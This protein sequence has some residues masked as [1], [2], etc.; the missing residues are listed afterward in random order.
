[1]N[2]VSNTIQLGGHVFDLVKNEVRVAPDGPSMSCLAAVEQMRVFHGHHT[3]IECV[4]R[5]FQ[6]NDKW[7]KVRLNK[8]G[9]GRF[10]FVD[11][12]EAT[13]PTKA[14]NSTTELFDHLTSRLAQ[15]AIQWT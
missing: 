4:F 5:R 10:V 15:A 7:A 14:F 2:N 13:V 1:M 9:A 8:N 6:P 12:T 3:G 11:F